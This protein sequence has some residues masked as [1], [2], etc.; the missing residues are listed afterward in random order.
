MFE[1]DLTEIEAA[2]F[3]EGYQLETPAESF[4]DLDADHARRPFWRRLF[5]RSDRE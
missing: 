5:S 4:A 1:D 3:A 2:F